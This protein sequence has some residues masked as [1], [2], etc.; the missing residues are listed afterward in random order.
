MVS[1]ILPRE[2]PVNQTPQLF[3]STHFCRKDAFLL[4]SCTH[5]LWYHR[6]M[7]ELFLMYARYSQRANTSVLELVKGL[8]LDI[9]NQPDRGYYGSLNEMIA[10]ILGGTLYFLR[11][12]S[13]GITTHRDIFE[14]VSG[15]AVPKGKLDDAG[16]ADMTET[17]AAAD[18]A[19]VSLV[20]QLAPSELSTPIPLDWYP[21]RSTV[22]FYFLFNQLIVH[23]I[24]HRG[25]IS[26]VLDE[27]KVEH[28]FSG[29]DLAF[30]NP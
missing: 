8:P 9:R 13:M 4:L 20:T 28:D 12:F 16:F 24:H 23:G 6:D 29:I 2:A 26:Q 15:C 21:D 14:T 10:H 1:N 7:Q 25:Q 11:L 18:Q 19:V 22:P 30:L 17:F 3:D 27:L 5:H